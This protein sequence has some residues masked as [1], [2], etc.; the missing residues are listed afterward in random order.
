MKT[1]RRVAVTG[2]GVVSPVGTG[3]EAF[4]NG[5]MSS[6]PE[7]ERRVHDFDPQAFYENPKLARRADRFEQFAAAC[8]VEALE[9]SGM[10]GG[11]PARTESWPISRGVTLGMDLASSSQNQSGFQ[12]VYLTRRCGI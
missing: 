6:Q 12:A 4:W 5:L 11:D 2:A 10:P 3:R 7:G 8:A 1:A 9:Q